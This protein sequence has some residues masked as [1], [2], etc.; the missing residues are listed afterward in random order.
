MKTE[1]ESEVTESRHV[2]Q[3]EV[4]STAVQYTIYIEVKKEKR[5]TPYIVR[6]GFW[7]SVR[8][9]IQASVNMDTFAIR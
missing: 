3:C 1:I 4:H 6:H 5:A 7:L 2:S 8:K 9:I